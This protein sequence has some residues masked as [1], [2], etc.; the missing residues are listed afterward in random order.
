MVTN[1]TLK[2]IADILAKA[3]SVL[4]FPHENADGDAIGSCVGLCLALKSLGKD[5]WVLTGEPLAEYISFME[6][7]CC[8]TD[9]GCIENPEVCICIDCSENS[10][11]PGR[12][13][14]YRSGEKCLCIDHHMNREGYGQLY[15]IDEEEA[16]TA[17]I[18][19]KLMQEFEGL[20]LTKEM[21]NAIYAGISTDTG[22]FRYSNTT[23]ETL[24]IAAD[25]MELGIDHNMIIVNAFQ[26]KDRRE[27][28]V[29]TKAYE[30]MVFLAGGKGV[31]S[32]ITQDMLR[33]CNAEYEHVETAIDCL[34]DIEGVEIAAILKEK[35]AG[36][37]KGSLRAKS[38]GSVVG[39]AR[40]FNGGGHEK[41]A[42]CSFRCSMEEALQQLKE[43]VLQECEKLQ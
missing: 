12:L 4:L 26:N 43:A 33:Q 41:A 25:L 36:L 5:A 35:E 18:I 34:R 38:S 9:A 7:G 40:A 1:T 6:Y 10:R 3:D 24:R 31:V 22:N 30:N 15:Y 39:I 37:I 17:G 32:Y 23:A 29:Q 2:E 20:E 21:G 8:T 28:A 13:D 16:A 14:K 11:I 27:I 19:Y 42:G